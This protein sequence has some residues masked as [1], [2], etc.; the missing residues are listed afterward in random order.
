[1][2][3][4]KAVGEGK[5]AAMMPMAPFHLAAVDRLVAAAAADGD[6]ERRVAYR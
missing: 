1:M 6:A 4:P 5:L 2:R 3:Q